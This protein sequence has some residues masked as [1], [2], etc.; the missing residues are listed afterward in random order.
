VS[1]PLTL[2]G[3]FLLA[4]AVTVGVTPL[5]I[6]LATRFD[7]LDR[8]AGY[9]QHARATPYL[10]GLAVVAGLTVSAAVF[11]SGF[12]SL[13]V[14]L[15]CAVI[16]MAVGTL[17]DRVGL[18]PGIRVLVTAGVA[19]LLFEADLGWSVFEDDAANLILTL[20]FVLATVNAFNLMDNLD[21]AT[22]TVA[23]VAGL[24][25]GVLS[26]L[27]GSVELGAVCLALAGACAGFLRY[28]LTQPARIFLGDGGSM[29]VGLTIAAAIMGLPR[30]TGLDTEMILV[31]VVLVGLPALDTTLVIVSRLRRG[32]TVLTGGRDHLTHR[33]FARVGSTRRVA[34]ALAVGQGALAVVAILLY[35]LDPIFTLVGAL[36]C[37]LIGIVIVAAL[38]IPRPSG[39]RGLERAGA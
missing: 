33:L 25:I 30:H 32:V 7:L 13:A 36:A 4:S 9:K 39:V 1:D 28:N 12:P 16:L 11:A 18:G 37:I 3:S 24:G 14:L 29:P 2:A 5:A 38:E 27:E 10:G 26:T 23:G 8:P 15:L 6:R 34:V 20:I 22:G 31:A 35:Q 19:V 21:G 17:D